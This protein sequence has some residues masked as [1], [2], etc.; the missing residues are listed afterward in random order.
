MTSQELAVVLEKLAKIEHKQDEYQSN[1]L[2]S[3]SVNENADASAFVSG[4]GT[5]SGK[6][7]KELLEE[8][9][10]SITEIKA[11]IKDLA[12]QIEEKEKRMD[13]LEQYG[14]SNCLILHGCV[15]LPKEN[16]GYVTFENFV[17]DTLNSRL[18]F[19]HPI[20]NSDIDICHVLPSR[21]GKNR[22]IIKFVRR[23]VRNQVFNCKSL[24]KAT[25]ESDPKLAKTESL[26][27]RRSK[28]LEQ[29]KKV[30]GFQN[31]WTQKGNIFCSFEGKRHR[32]N[33]FTNIARIRFPKK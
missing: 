2:N 1:F 6:G 17:L 33:D 31:V 8:L 12:K 11:K 22:I 15:D 7:Q 28:L 9:S 20:H 26:T 30:F 24:L 29:F 10:Q 32:I 3:S 23:S 25:K 5:S 14:R 27:R 18:K 19:A 4:T 13:D 16:A 21:K